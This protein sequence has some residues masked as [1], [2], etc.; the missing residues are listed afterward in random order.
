MT[1]NN[2]AIEKM[3]ETEWEHQRKERAASPSWIQMVPW[4]KA[5]EEHKEGY[6]VGVRRFLAA[7]PLR[8][9]LGSPEAEAA[10]IE[11]KAA[12]VPLVDAQG[13]ES[14]WLHYM[15]LTGLAPHIDP[16]RLDEMR[17]DKPTDKP[18]HIE[19][20]RDMVEST[21]TPTLAKSATVAATFFKTETV[22]DKPTDTTTGGGI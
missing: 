22:H 12:V 18:N 13:R 14:V 8:A 15:H 21:D 17:L 4:S 19:D 11:R 3:A 16:I 5:T 20:V 10:I 7:D 1:Q 6:R 2:D 9:A